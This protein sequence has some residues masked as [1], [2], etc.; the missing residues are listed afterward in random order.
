[1]SGLALL[2]SYQDD[3]VIAYS[4]GQRV[5]VASFLQ[6]VAQLAALLPSRH[7]MF[8]LCADRYRFMVGFCAAL[9]RG[10]INLLPPNHTPD[11]I[12]RLTQRYSGIYCLTDGADD[13]G[14]LETLRYP[15][16]TG[17]GTR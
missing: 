15:A 1:M 8:N 2:R 9:V 14:T 10:Q 12:G 4:D 13:Y 6:D 5:G 16:M 17:A 7:H 3:A 11:L